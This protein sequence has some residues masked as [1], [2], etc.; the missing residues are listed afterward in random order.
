MYGVR[1]INLFIFAIITASPGLA[2]ATSLPPYH[3]ETHTYAKSA[4]YCFSRG[5]WSGDSALMTLSYQLVVTTK[6][7]ARYGDIFVGFRRKS[8]PTH[9]WLLGNASQGEKTWLQY[10]G[11][12][13]PASFETSQALA[14]VTNLSIISKPTDLKAVA[15][16]AEV[17]VGYGLRP[18]GSLKTTPTDS[19]QEMLVNERFKVIWNNTQTQS[20][21]NFICINYSDITERVDGF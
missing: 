14:P 11:A 2:L 10:D 21:G 18:N 4:Q 8:D 12:S 17:L 6:N 15:D 9:L 20:F 3:T 16:D 13:I 5:E 1:T 7:Q 19:F